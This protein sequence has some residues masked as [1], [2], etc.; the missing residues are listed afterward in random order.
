MGRWLDTGRLVR[1]EAAPCPGRLRRTGRSSVGSRGWDLYRARPTNDGYEV[2]S[3]GL[4]IN[5]PQ[6][7]T[8]IYVDPEQR[9]IVFVRT[10]DPEGFGGDDLYY[11][12]PTETGW[13]APR[14]LGAAVNTPEYEYGPLISWDGTRLY[15][16]SH[17][18]GPADIYEADVASL[19]IGP[20]TEPEP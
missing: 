19:G 3:L 2:E 13:S 7:E 16:T 15:F 8:D 18:D 4:D 20:A 12:E 10:D 9:F 17:K 14:N 5:T 6:S 11:S 1:P